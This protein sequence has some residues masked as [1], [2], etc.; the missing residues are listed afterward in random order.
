MTLPISPLAIGID[1][2]GT[3]IKIAV[4]RGSEIVKRGTSLD[5][6]RLATPAAICDAIAS[7][8][9]SLRRDD[10][11]ITAIGAGLPGMVDASRGVVHEL[12]NV[13]G[14][15]EVPLG[16]I[17][18][19]RTGLPATVDNDAKA[20][21]YAEW[22]FGAARRQPNTVCM[23]LGTG[24]GGGLILNG[25]L[26]RGS[27]NGAGEIGQAT[28]DFKG[29]PGHY[30][31]FGALEKYVGNQQI[32]KRAHRR[33]CEAGS[34]E[35]SPE[36]CSPAAL[37]AAAEAGDPVAKTIWEEVGTEIGA[38]LASIVWL[39]NPDCI[40]IGGGVAQAGELLFG[41]IRAS[42]RARTMPLYYEHLDILPATLGSDA[43]VIGAAA[44]GVDACG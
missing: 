33:Y 11:G 10:P 43:G 42:I 22:R 25:K 19:E 18:S 23:T 31:N 5:T 21:T 8:I 2:G 16:R 27:L 15:D 12:S 6:Q 1:F 26:F 34:G 3:S 38:A 14:W 44:L 36:E 20:M 40:V 9:A 30:G 4:V 7:D 37:A 17:L 24:V 28:I 39:L 32:A 35:R 41:P 29:A 13:S